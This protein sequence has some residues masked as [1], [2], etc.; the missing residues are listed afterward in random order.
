HVRA[1]PLVELLV[2]AL[3]RQVQVELAERR[4]E[5]VRVL[6]REGVAAR[7]RDLEAVA[8]RQLRAADDT[9]EDPAA[10]DPLE[11]GRLLAVAQ[12]ADRARVRAVDTDDHAVL[13][14][15]RAEEVVR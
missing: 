6:E 8:E 3:R 10:I 14:L 12:D 15:V 9:L 2:P 13:V 1:E 11:L 4:Q 5:R 7:I